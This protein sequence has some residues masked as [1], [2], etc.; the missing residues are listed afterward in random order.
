[1]RLG[2]VVYLAAVGVLGC[3]PQDP[4]APL[5]QARKEINDVEAYQYQSWRLAPLQAALQRALSQA[6]AGVIRNPRVALCFGTSDV[7]P[8]GARLVVK[9][10]ML[11]DVR[12]DAP[13]ATQPASREPHN[14]DRFVQD[15]IRAALAH[16]GWEVEDV[17]TY[18]YENCWR[19]SGQIRGNGIAPSAGTGA[20]LLPPRLPRGE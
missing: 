2:L 6:G 1:M 5:D 14:R 10:V 20:E 17:Y 18:D 16:C 13:R 9:Y 11:F 8:L 12:P 4:R 7:P 19:V 3:Q 15:I